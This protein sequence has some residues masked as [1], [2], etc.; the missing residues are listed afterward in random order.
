MKETLYSVFE[1]DSRFD[2]GGIVFDTFQKGK[3]FFVEVT[4]NYQ[5]MNIPE[6]ND[7]T[8]SLY[9]FNQKGELELVYQIKVKDF[10]RM[11]VETDLKDYTKEK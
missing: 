2:Y 8:M 10:S 6:I 4:S 9:K 7:K 1:E 11:K 5:R 3:H